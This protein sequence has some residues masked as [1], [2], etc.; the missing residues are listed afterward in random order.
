MKLFVNNFRISK[1]AEDTKELTR[2][3]GL[4]LYK[5]IINSSGFGENA[6]F[7]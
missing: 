4:T 2:A 7:T 1:T 6:L 3:L 5:S